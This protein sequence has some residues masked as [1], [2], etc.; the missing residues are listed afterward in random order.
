MPG[1][2][3]VDTNVLIY[4]HDATSGSRHEQARSVVASLWR[5][6]G[7]VISTQVLQE[8]AVNIQRKTRFPPAP[9]VVGEWLADYLQWE[10]V[11][12]DGAA[13]LEALAVQARYQISFWDALI[14]QAANAAGA[15]ILYSEDLNHGQHYGSVL[16][17][18]PFL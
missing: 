5:E 8:F 17:R 9:G 13:V 3:F 15:Q 4:A 12:N 11:I 16:A 10:V 1:K 2:C 18:N 6:G 14:V 7:A